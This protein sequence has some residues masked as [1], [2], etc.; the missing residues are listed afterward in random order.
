MSN[1]D[2]EYLRITDTSAR[3]DFKKEEKSAFKA[4]KGLSEDTIRVISE[5]KGE[6]EWMLNRR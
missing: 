4:E 2:E 3:F 1:A 6:P 5:D